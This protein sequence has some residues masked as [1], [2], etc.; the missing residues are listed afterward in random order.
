MNHAFYWL[1]TYICLFLI[2]YTPEGNAQPLSIIEICDNGIDDDGDGLI[3]CFDDDCCDMCGEHYYDPCVAGNED[4]I[5]I[6]TGEFSIQ[7]AWTYGNDWN[8]YNTPIAGDIDNDGT[9]EIVGKRGVVDGSW[10]YKDLLIVNGAD[11][12]LQE[13][14][15]TPF[16]RHPTDG[17]MIADVDKDGFAE[18][19]IQVSNHASNTSPRHIYCYKSNGGTYVLDWISDQAVGYNTSKEGVILGV[20]DFNGD[21]RPEIYALNQI[22]DSYTGIKIAEGGASNNQGTVSDVV[23]KNVSVAMDVLPDESCPSCEGLELV[24]GT[25][26][27]SVEINP[28]ALSGVLTV[29][30]NATTNIDGYTSVADM[31]LDGDLDA[32]IASSVGGNATITICDLQTSAI[33]YNSYSFPT[34]FSRVSLPTIGNISGGELPEIVVTGENKIRV[35]SLESGNLDLLWEQNTSDPSGQTRSTLFDFDFDGIKEVIMR[36]NSYLNI[37]KGDTGAVIFQTFCSSGTGWEVPTFVDIDLDDE[38]ELLCSC[39]NELR[40]Y[41]SATSS[42]ANTRP[43]WNQHAFFNV[44][45]NDDLTVPVE[46]QQQ[47]HILSPPDMNNFVVPYT[48]GYAL[49]PDFDIVEGTF[50]CDNGQ[51]ELWLEWCNIG[52]TNANGPIPISLYDG[53]T[54]TPVFTFQA[55][56]NLLVGDCDTITISVPGNLFSSDDVLIVIGDD[57]GSSAPYAETDFPLSSIIECTYHNNQFTIDLPT[58]QIVALD[59]GADLNLCP[60]DSVTLT[61]TEIYDSYIWQDGDTSTTY[62]ITEPGDYW[63]E[64][65]NNCGYFAIDTISVNWFDSPIINTNIFPVC[66]NS[67]NGSISIE[68]SG[69]N[70]PFSVYFNGLLVDTTSA[71][72]WDSLASGI[73]LIDIVDGNGCSWEVQAEVEE[74]NM[75]SYEVIAED[76]SCNG[77]SDGNIQILNADDG[78][79]FSLNYGALDSV[80]IFSGLGPGSYSITMIDDSGCEIEMEFILQEPMPLSIDLPAQLEVELGC[81]IQ[82]P[83]IAIYD[84]PVSFIWD[85]VEGLDC[86]DCI[87]PD[88]LVYSNQI[89][90]VIMQDSSG[91]ED[92]ASTELLITF[93]ESVYIPNAF[94]PNGDGRNDLFTVFAGKAVEQI[95]K[96]QIFDRWGELIFQNENIPP[97]DLMHAWDGTFLNRKMKPAV[98]VYMV[99]VL[100]LDGSIQKYSGDLQLVR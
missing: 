45:I 78:T 14:I 11:G 48:D 4:C 82:L 79:L 54:G 92:S 96:I 37:Y 25:Q 35:L 90:N 32:I 13:V 6:P 83:T 19:F 39:G 42:W 9:I 61:V 22:F 21:D 7:L 67:S 85:P 73:Y 64:V 99:E 94:S 44:N 57:G 15:S 24:C 34:T 93:E 12:S 56:G 50:N 80:S 65:R 66:N 52:S 3:D 1:L 68:M 41:E 84:R 100:L 49:L 75:D 97:N 81:P 51:L 46:Q 30:T 59:L 31:D 71:F 60:G 72:H 86:V 53:N 8:N 55:E 95:Q 16:M 29:E 76:I 18:I 47:Q 63:L 5:E 88:A 62:T 2:S 36:D 43:V 20:A 26:V 89:Y 98:F 77:Y 40:A 58:S 38:A 28:V 10:N 23:M 27:Y 74:L 70:P 69:V 33:L 87:R 91:C 17:V